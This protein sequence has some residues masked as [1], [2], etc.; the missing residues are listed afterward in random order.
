MQR[1]AIV[2]RASLR[3]ICNYYYVN[4]GCIFGHCIYQTFVGIKHSFTFLF[5]RVIPF[6]L[7]LSNVI[8]FILGSS[9]NILYAHFTAKL[10][11]YLL[12][13]T[14]SVAYTVNGP[15]FDKFAGVLPLH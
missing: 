3:G 11:V 8:P 2:S 14:L 4:F 10:P 7:W 9:V 6:K 5:Y 12:S 1:L 13:L 15:G